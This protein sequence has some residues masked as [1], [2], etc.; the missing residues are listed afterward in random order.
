MIC[1]S[2]S[3]KV[4]CI[5][6]SRPVGTHVVNAMGIRR[7]HNAKALGGATVRGNMG[8]MGL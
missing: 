2:T 6:S 8:N 7:A 1:R 5:T 3:I 4:P